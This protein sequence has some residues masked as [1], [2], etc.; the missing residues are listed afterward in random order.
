VAARHRGGALPVV[1]SDGRSLT[2]SLILLT[3]PGGSDAMALAAEARRTF[4]TVVVVT[5]VEEP[6]ETWTPA[7]E[8]LPPGVQ[9]AV[10]GADEPFAPAWQAL[11]VRLAVGRR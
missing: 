4:A 2:G 5:V 7:P 1:P 10:L 6:T 8:P 9:L 11:L 3:G